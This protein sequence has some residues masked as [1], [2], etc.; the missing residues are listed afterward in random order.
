MNDAKKYDEWVFILSG[1]L[2]ITYCILC[3]KVTT[4]F[5][6]VKLPFH[7]SPERTLNVHLFFQSLFILLISTLLSLFL[8]TIL[9]K[10][11]MSVH[12]WDASLINTSHRISF[13]FV[14]SLG[15]LHVLSILY[16]HTCY[17]LFGNQK[18]SDIL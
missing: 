12:T 11:C 1:L 5:T 3:I 9:Y 14:Y 13:L 8:L 7:K 16:S 4:V 17:I 10:I 15:L 6:N 18:G 2:L